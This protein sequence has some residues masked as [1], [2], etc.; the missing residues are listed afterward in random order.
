[1]DILIITNNLPESVNDAYYGTMTIIVNSQVEYLQRAGYT[2]SVLCLYSSEKASLKHLY[3]KRESNGVKIYTSSIWKRL[4]KYPM[5]VNMLAHVLVASRIFL[6]CGKPK[7][8]HCHNAFHAGLVGRSISAFF[9]VPFIVT[10]HL[11]WYA[12]GIFKSSLKNKLGRVF[13]SAQK[14]L[15]VSRQL[16]EDL[17]EVFGRNLAY[18]T[19]PNFVDEAFFEQKINRQQRANRFTFL[20]ISKLSEKKNQD[21]L[22]T[23]FAR[24]F[25]GDLSI[26][27][28]I[29][30]R[31]RQLDALL[32]LCK[33]HGI[34]NQVV[35]TGYLS[36]S[37]IM[38]EIANCDVYVMSSN[39]ETFAIPI[40]EAMAFGKPVVATRCGGP[41][42]IV[43]DQNGLLVPIQN[44]NAMSMAME[45]MVSDFNLYDEA[46]IKKYCFENYSKTIVMRKL[47]N[48][49]DDFL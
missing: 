40:I 47:C 13:R 33:E 7:L 8:I 20:T 5:G 14:V 43:N 26:T 31:G 38:R 35:F 17:R 44:V 49:Y 42:D 36:R 48:L 45:K 12:R 9:S 16:G 6:E 1:V 32:A 46:A 28:R 2:V 41:N 27:L 22:I 29:V 24:S 18:T 37:E 39:Y 34:E 11:S 3:W 4:E 30:G 21:I 25:R 23:A 15:V 19:I 10:E